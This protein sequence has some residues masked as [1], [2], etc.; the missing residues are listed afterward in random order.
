M[1][2]KVKNLTADFYL[3]TSIFCV[4]I[5]FAANFIVPSH[6]NGFTEG[7]NLSIQEVW[8]SEG[9][10]QFFTDRY[11]NSEFRRRPFVLE[12]QHF[13]QTSWG[14]PHQFSF[15]LINYVSLFLFIYLLPI[16]SKT[17][18]RQ[19]VE[20]AYIAFF[21]LGSMPI[22]FA[23]YGSIFS[24]DDFVQYLLLTIFLIF[25][26]KEQTLAAAIALTLACIA[27]ETSFIF[28]PLVVIHDFFVAKKPLKKVL[29]WGIPIVG[30]PVFL[31][32]YLDNT[33]LN[34]SKDF[35]VE[36][37]FYVW[38]ENFKNWQAI[39]ESTTI[40]ALMTALPMLLLYQKYKTT[41]VPEMRYWSRVAMILIVANCLI[42][43]TTGLV[44]EARLFFVPLVLAIPIIH[45]EIKK[46][47]HLLTKKENNSNYL[48][49][50]GIVLISFVLAFVWF[51]PLAVGTGYIY[52]MYGFVYF[53]IFLKLLML[54]LDK[55]NKH[56][57]STRL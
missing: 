11:R 33:L 37:R 19:S 28:L 31:Y 39:R 26:F 34:R 43:V 14:I 32:S 2:Q 16:L 29:L 40:L 48:K 23:F 46:S 9:A 21:V 52:K 5:V 50:G 53:L 47:W 25:F 36:K 24:Y 57:A 49:N 30:Y 18:N 20:P 6:A 27:R 22:I 17:I 10:T 41:Q 51:S 13:M 54:E 1:K 8:E 15:N 56:L 55:K 35:L 7:L 45:S 3:L 42:V 38:I 4:L 12:F 44:R